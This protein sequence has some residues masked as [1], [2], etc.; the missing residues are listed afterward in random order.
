MGLGRDWLQHMRSRQRNFG[1]FGFGGGGDDSQE[2]FRIQETSLAGMYVWLSVWHMCM[3]RICGF[4]YGAGP[5]EVAFPQTLQSH[6]RRLG[7]GPR[8]RAGAI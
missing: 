1:P 4:Y 2:P 7:A 6:G 8:R 5:A 3:H